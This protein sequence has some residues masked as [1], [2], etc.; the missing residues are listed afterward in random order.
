MGNEISCRPWPPMLLPEQ[1]GSSITPLRWQPT[2]S[3]AASLGDLKSQV[4]P[5]Y[6]KGSHQLLTP[7][8]TVSRLQ[9]MK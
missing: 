1:G 4:G 2:C 9:G 3:L 6:K 7:Q 8:Q 5:L